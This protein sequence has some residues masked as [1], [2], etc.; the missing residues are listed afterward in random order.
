MTSDD[1]V[2]EMRPRAE[3]RISAGLVHD[4]AAALDELRELT[5]YNDA[6]IVNRALQVYAFIE[7]EKRAGAKLLVT[8]PGSRGDLREVTII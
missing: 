4:G 7:R 2:T 8:V 6:T 3:R 1:N 5:G